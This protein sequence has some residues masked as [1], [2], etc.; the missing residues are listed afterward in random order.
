[1]DKKE[2]LEEIRSAEMV[3][4]GIGGDALRKSAR[5]SE[6]HRDVVYE[7]LMKTPFAWMAPVWA[8]LGMSREQTDR[9]KEGLEKLAGMLEGKNYYVLS[10]SESSLL[11]GVP[12]REGRLIMPCGCTM[13]KKCRCREKGIQKLTDEEWKAMVEATTQLPRILDGVYDRICAAESEMMGK[14]DEPVA[15]AMRMIASRQAVEPCIPALEESFTGLLGRCEDCKTDYVLQV[16]ESMD[17]DRTL[18]GDA[19]LGYSKWIQGIPN[20]KVLLLILGRAKEHPE[21]IREPFEK[22]AEL[23]LTSKLVWI[24]EQNHSAERMVLKKA[25]LIEENVIECLCNL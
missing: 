18:Y 3:L 5:E 19:W 2:L 20:R 1:M 17:F 15:T 22:I 23:I 4:I 6:D 8:E 25:E 21:Q 7:T 14:Y 11:C 16:E 24:A 10:N 13:A 12:W 9:A